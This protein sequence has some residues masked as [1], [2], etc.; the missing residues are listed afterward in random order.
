MILVVD[1]DPDFLLLTER[2]LRM[3]EVMFASD[4]KHA[5][6]L[7]SSLGDEEFSVALVDLNLTGESGFELISKLK[8]AFPRLPVIA[9]S[10][11]YLGAGLESA[12]SIGAVATLAKPITREWNAVVNR[13]STRRRSA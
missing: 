13:Y 6:S 3:E 7:L 12:R 8:A 1:D 9:I 11:Y 2:F 10:G 4:A 5:L